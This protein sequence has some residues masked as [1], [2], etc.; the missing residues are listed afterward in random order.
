[1]NV[2]VGVISPAA[3][4]NIPP[5]FV[6]RLRSD[7]PEHRFLD[8]W[9]DQAIRRW[10]PE[11][12]AA[13]TPLVDRDVFPSA[14]RLRWV[15]VPAVGV[16]HLLYP[17]LVESPVVITNA[18][19]VRSRAMAEHVIGVIIALA[20]QFHVAFGHQAARRWAQD[21]LE[22]GGTNGTIRTLQGRR[23]GIVG[24]GSI[25]M[26][27]AGLAAPFG[28]R[29]SAIRRRAGLPLPVNV[30]E[31]LPPGRLDDLLAGSDIVVLAAP[32]TP[33]TDRMIGRH[34]LSVMKPG[35]LIVNIGR[36][37]LVDDQAL[38]DALRSRHLGGAALDV[39]T[40]EPLD[41]LSPYWDL[42][43]VMVTPHI[44]GAMEDYWTPLVALFSENLRRFE[45][46]RP[47]LNVVDKRA[48]Y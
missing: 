18:R 9:D 1:M 31:I 24:F 21:L 12:D 42:P 23:L 20:R 46:G 2:L 47:L 41:P 19:G 37:A 28:M 5:S 17:A 8:A 36:G 16:G 45:A 26:E 32:L 48:G 38:V 11:A 14:T 15:Q 10:L 13:F 40:E 35:A 34:E 3:A 44:S 27:I 30:D 25:G 6:D 33:A 29:I 7:F 39:F 4:W 22:Q 43:N